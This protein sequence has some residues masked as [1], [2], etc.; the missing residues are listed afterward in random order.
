MITLNV[1]LA[2]MTTQIQDK[3]NDENKASENREEQLIE[4]IQNLNQ[5]IDR[6]EKKINESKEN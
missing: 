6:L 1:F 2:V 5:K 3:L 4:A